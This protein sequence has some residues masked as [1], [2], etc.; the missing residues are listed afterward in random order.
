M[1][2]CDIVFNCLIDDLNSISCQNLWNKFFFF[3]QIQ[4]HHSTETSFTTDILI[5]WNTYLNTQENCKK[6]LTKKCFYRPNYYIYLLLLST[7]FEPDS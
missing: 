3:Y 5:K 1:E 6:F 4:P 7:D 2:A